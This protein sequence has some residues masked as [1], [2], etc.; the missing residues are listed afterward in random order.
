VATGGLVVAAAA[1]YAWLVFGPYARR[2]EQQADLFADGATPTSA[3]G[4]DPRAASALCAAL[5]K[6]A[7]LSGTGR[8]RGTWLHPS[9]AA[10]CEFML[11]AARQPRC[12]ARFEWWMR[13]TAVLLV[14]VNV[15]ALAVAAWPA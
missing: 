12:A 2:L 5:E 8:S 1:A 14:A 13:I 15:A 3:G 10:R 6:L 9:V 7:V 4:A 11:R